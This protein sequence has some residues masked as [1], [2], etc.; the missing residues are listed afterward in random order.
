MIWSIKSINLKFNPFFIKQYCF[1]LLVVCGDNNKDKIYKE[2]ILLKYWRFLVKSISNI[3]DDTKCLKCKKY[4][5][6][7]SSISNRIIMPFKLIVIWAIIEK[8][9]KE[10]RSIF[11]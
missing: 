5:G 6:N 9:L 3:S 10:T 2:R 7:K 11:K 4:T 8:I 1:L